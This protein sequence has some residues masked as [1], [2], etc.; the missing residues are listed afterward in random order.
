MD[1]ISI[2]FKY[3]C[4]YIYFKQ[5]FLVITKIYTAYHYINCW[6]LLYISYHYKNCMII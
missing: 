1:S 3:R 6:K 2:I 4:M 5:M